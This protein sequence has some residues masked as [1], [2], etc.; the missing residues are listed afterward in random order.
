MSSGCVLYFKIIFLRDR[1]EYRR[2]LSRRGCCPDIPQDG[3]ALFNDT[4][5]CS[6][7]RKLMFIPSWH[8]TFSEDHPHFWWLSVD[9]L[10]SD[11]V[12]AGAT[13]NLDI[14]K[15]MGFHW[16]ALHLPRSKSWNRFFFSSSSFFN[17]KS[18]LPACLWVIEIFVQLPAEVMAGST[19]LLIKHK[20][21]Q[22]TVRKMSQFVWKTCWQMSKSLDLSLNPTVNC[23]FF[24]EIRKPLSPVAIITELFKTFQLVDENPSS[25][26][27]RFL[28]EVTGIF[29]K[30]LIM[31]EFSFFFTF[32]SR[33][34]LKCF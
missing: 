5:A 4:R 23:L 3:A 28:A 10:F 31:L 19:D 2:I 30:R 14:R 15:R 8:T 32:I 21:Y 7:N 16:N 27:I 13:A 9:V 24:K 33:L 1:A 12:I 20:G 29:W 34:F 17:F 22:W 26:S 18:W 6:L 11:E 25:S